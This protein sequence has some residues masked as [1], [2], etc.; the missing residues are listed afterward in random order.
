M[1]KWDILTFIIIIIITFNKSVSSTCIS[2]MG[3]TNN[4]SNLKVD[5]ITNK[6]T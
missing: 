5:Y 2:I 3:V 4:I 6:I 1:I